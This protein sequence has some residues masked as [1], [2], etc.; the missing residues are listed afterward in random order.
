MYVIVHQKW[1]VI[2]IRIAKEWVLLPLP[3]KKKD[4]VDWRILSFFLLP[5]CRLRS[6]RLVTQTGFHSN[7]ASNTF[8]QIVHGLPWFTAVPL[9]VSPIFFV[10]PTNP[11]GPPHAMA[12]AVS[13]WSPVTITTYKVHPHRFQGPAAAFSARDNWVY[14]N[15]IYCVLYLEVQDT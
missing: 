15:G 12:L 11:E 9:I 4:T 2:P 1:R 14:P 7:W 3:P 6:F 8:S 5:P 13:G 10:F